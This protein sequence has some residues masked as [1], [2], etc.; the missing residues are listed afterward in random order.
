MTSG[1][2]LNCAGLDQNEGT[3]LSY[4]VD[5]EQCLNKCNSSPSAKGCEHGPGGACTI[6]TQDVLKGNGVST[7]K[8]WTHPNSCQGMRNVLLFSLFFLVSLFIL[9][10]HINCISLLQ[11]ADDLANFFQVTPSQTRV[12]S[13]N[14]HP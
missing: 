2:C 11:D 1:W 5:L 9:Y 6:H 8:C 13:I 4:G 14:A 10:L 12:S 7:Y 3:S